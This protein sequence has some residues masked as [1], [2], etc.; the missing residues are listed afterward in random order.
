MNINKAVDKAYEGKSLKELVG[1]SVDALQGL[2]ENDA[3][4]LKDAFN[5]KTIEDLANLKFVKWAQA[6]VAL[7]AAEA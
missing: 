3:K 1:A 6:I 2:S 7:A 5:V 4:L